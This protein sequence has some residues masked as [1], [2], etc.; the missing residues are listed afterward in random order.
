L[1]DRGHQLQKNLLRD[2]TSGGR[3]AVKE[4]KRDGVDL[5]LVVL[6]KSA[7]GVAVSAAASLE[8]LG[9]DLGLTQNSPP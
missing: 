3:V 6:V 2:I 5:V 9:A 4:I 1:P 8:D 7:E